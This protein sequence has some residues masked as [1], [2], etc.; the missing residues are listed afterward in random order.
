MW[1]QRL[2]SYFF[3]VDCYIFALIRLTDPPVYKTIKTYFSSCGSADEDQYPTAEET[4]SS[5]LMS[6]LNVELVYT[7]LT[8]IVD[9]TENPELQVDTSSSTPVASMTLNS[10]KIK[11]YKFWESRKNQSL[12]MR[13]INSEHVSTFELN[14]GVSA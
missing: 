2:S 13:D 9:F 10:I 14:L 12:A 11:D 1:F 3:S 6:Q 8:G 7:I 5:F 4:M